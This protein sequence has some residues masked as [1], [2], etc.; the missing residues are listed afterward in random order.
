MQGYRQNGSDYAG[1]QVTGLWG[2]G[3][4]GGNAEIKTMS[5]SGVPLRFA[6]VPLVLVCELVNCCPHLLSPS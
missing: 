3:A 4:F 2:C 5:F 1:G 6:G